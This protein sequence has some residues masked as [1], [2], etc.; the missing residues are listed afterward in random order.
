MLIFIII[1]IIIIFFC[2]LG[3]LTIHIMVVFTLNRIFCGK[4]SKFR[5]IFRGKF[6]EKSANFV[7]KKSKFVE[8]LADFAGFAQ[9]KRQNS[10]KNQ[11][12]SQDFSGKNSNFEGFSGANSRFRWIVLANFAKIDSIFASL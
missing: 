2:N 3:T 7:E 9:E 1:T 6:A 5:G 8:K 11:L 12:I 4:K 10:R